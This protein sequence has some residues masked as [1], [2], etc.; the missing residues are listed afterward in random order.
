[1][2][3][4]ALRRSALPADQPLGRRGLSGAALE[5]M[6]SALA[7]LVA[8]IDADLQH[9]EAL[10]PRMKDA[11]EAGQADLAVATR[12][13]AGGS[14]DFASRLAPRAFVARRACWC[15]ACSAFA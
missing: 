8:V 4:A 14:G 5:G 2:R 7:P 9:D 1:M 12:Y 13:A 15:G 11:L 10:L 6:L 3:A